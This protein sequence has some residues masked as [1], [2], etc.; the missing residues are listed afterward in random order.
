MK[1]SLAVAALWAIS[2]VLA[3]MDSAYGTW[4]SDDLAVCTAPNDQ[5]YPSIAPDGVGGAFVAWEDRRVSIPFGYFPDIYVQRVSNAGDVLW[6]ANGIG[7]V[8]TPPGQTTTRI[9]SDASGGAVVLWSEWQSRDVAYL[10]A[11]R[12]NG[13][14]SLQWGAAGVA[15]C[16]GG[17]R[18]ESPEMIPDGAGGAIVVWRDWRN[19]DLNDF[20]VY[21]QRISQ[22]GT[23]EW[24]ANGTALCFISGAQVGARV[25]SDGAGGAIVAW[26]D[27]RHGY[28]NTDIYVQRVM[29]SGVPLWT[30]NGVEACTATDEQDQLQ[31][32]ADDHG[33]A[34]ICWRDRHD[35]DA[36]I[37]AQRVNS[38]GVAEWPNNGLLVCGAVGEQ[39]EPRLISDETGGAIIAWD[40]LRGGSGSD[41]YSQRIDGNGVPQWPADGIPICTSTGGQ[42][43]IGLVT[44]GFG[45]AII[46]WDDQ[47]SGIPRFYAQ[48]TTMNG[49]LQW[50]HDGIPVSSAAGWQYA[51]VITADGMGTAILA[52]MDER[53]GAPD[54][55]AQHIA[56]SPSGISPATRALGS[57]LSRNVPNP[58]NPRTMICFDLPSAGP[59]RLAVYDLAGRLVRTLIDESMPQGSH[60]AVW[61]GRDSSGREVGSGGYLARLEFGG[62]VETV[63]MGLI[64]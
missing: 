25:A 64:R 14:G 63:R 47:R 19:S 15:I 6:T 51:P 57:M 53:S 35:G 42:A 9:V 59:V 22:S 36:N 48:R 20:D 26:E 30:A 43:T 37:Y 31:L 17:G 55:Y 16:T 50:T 23:V 5:N 3:G 4:P 54:I 32:I 8:T 45:G 41:V 21:A 40:D 61:D 13:E 29:E 52:W 49:D 60:E 38:A 7:V 28:L 18:P 1:S 39:S 56:L 46:T 24:T 34:I 33:G 44:D 62:K 27:D 12:L 58:F 2:I 11:Q 10:Y